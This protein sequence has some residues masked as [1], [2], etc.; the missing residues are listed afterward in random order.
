MPFSA[1][2]MPLLQ[3]SKMLNRQIFFQFLREFK[4]SHYFWRKGEAR[5]MSY[6]AF[7]LVVIETSTV[8]LGKALTNQRCPQEKYSN[9][10]CFLSKS[11]DKSKVVL[12]KA[13]KIEGCLKESAKRSKDSLTK[14]LANKMRPQE[15][16]WEIRGF[17]RKTFTN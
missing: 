8:C 14:A 11:I 2:N 10:E 16:R 15:M 17:L 13:L 6:S 5:Q 3:T 1:K 4:T 9:I 12:G 7:N